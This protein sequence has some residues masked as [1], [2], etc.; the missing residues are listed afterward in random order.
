MAISL[1]RFI[2]YNMDYDV[3]DADGNLWCTAEM[4]TATIVVSLPSLKALIVKPAPNNTYDRS[5]SG[6]LQAGSSK[7]IGSKSNRHSSHVQGGTLDDDEM[8]LT[9]LDR[10][11]SPA[12]T[13]ATDETRV[14]DGKDAV[15]VTT[16]FTVTRDVHAPRSTPFLDLHLPLHP[17]LVPIHSVYGRVL[18][19]GDM[20]PGSCR[21]VPFS[22]LLLAWAGFVLAGDTITSGKIKV[23]LFAAPS[24]L[25]EVSVDAYNNQCLSLDNNLIDGRVQSILVGGHDVATVLQRDDY[26]SCRFYD[27]YDCDGDDN[28]DRYLAISDGANN[29]GSIAWGTKIHSLRCRNRDH[30][31]D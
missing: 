16:D 26:W 2:V 23:Q 27:N 17:R 31:D 20:M 9:F 13:G 21:L 24:F 22:T 19:A 11:A 3:A 6:Y 5:N 8:E 18:D 1:A 12:P 10:K 4:C 30:D 29:L 15:I 7:T 28:L 25:S 14:Q